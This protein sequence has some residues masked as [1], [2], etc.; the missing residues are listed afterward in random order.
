MPQLDAATFPSQLV[1]LAITFIALFAVMTWFGLPRVGAILAT[2]RKHIEDDLGSA[3]RMKDEAEAVIA[4]YEKALAEARD[5]AQATLRATV[6]RMNAASAARLKQLAGALAAETAAAERRIARGEERGARGPARCRGR[7][8]ARRGREGGGRRA[9]SRP[10]ARGGRRGAAGARV[11]ELLKDAEFWVLIAF[12]IA[13]GFLGWKAA[14]ILTRQ[15][16]QRAAKNPRR[17]RHRRAAPRRGADG[18][19]RIPEEA[20]RRLER[21]ERD[22]RAR[23]RGGGARRTS[24]PS[25]RSRRRSNAAA[26]WRARRSRSRRQ[27]PWPR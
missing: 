22:H 3:A 9:R 15:L 14:P 8:G 19:R 23:A 17:D 4:V 16:D 26:A 2:R 21:S 1:W 25:A 20:A 7:I 18:A 6:E 10:R 13:V 24:A 12:V 27:K 11:M 5:E